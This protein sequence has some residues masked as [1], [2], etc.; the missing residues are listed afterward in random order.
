MSSMFGI[1]NKN[2]SV[3]TKYVS[4]QIGNSVEFMIFDKYLENLE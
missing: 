3:A 4:R 2:T 1:L